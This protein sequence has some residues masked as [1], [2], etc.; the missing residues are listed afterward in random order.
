MGIGDAAHIKEF[1]GSLLFNMVVVFVIEV[2]NMFDAGLDDGLRA[3][4][5]WE[6]GDVDG[7]VL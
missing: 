2:D 5:T 4:V 6:E 7:A 3:F 1:A